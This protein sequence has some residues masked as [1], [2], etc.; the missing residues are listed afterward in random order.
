MRELLNSAVFGRNRLIDTGMIDHML[1][2]FGWR[3]GKNENVMPLTGRD[4]G[5]CAV[6]N[7]LHRD[8]IHRDGGLVPLAPLRRHYIEEPIIKFRE[9]VRPFGDLQGL[10]AGEC[11][12][13]KYK[14]R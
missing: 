5:E 2:V 12:R 9:K 6:A 10:L 14:K 7:V 11:V 1:V 4:F 8:H 3:P 13:R